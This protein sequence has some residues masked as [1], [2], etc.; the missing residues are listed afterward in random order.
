MIASK[1]PTIIGPNTSARTNV[2]VKELSDPPSLSAFCGDGVLSVEFGK[3]NKCR[4]AME[5][6]EIGWNIL[7]IGKNMRYK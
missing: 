2:S 7:W 4:V 6:E 1:I 5:W 3:D